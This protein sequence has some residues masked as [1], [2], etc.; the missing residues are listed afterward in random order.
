MKREGREKGWKSV[1]IKN[2]KCYKQ[3]YEN[4]EKKK[5]KIMMW[6]LIWLNKSIVIINATLQLLD[7]YRYRLKIKSIK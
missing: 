3:L 1:S 4:W 7:I 6:T 2:N 5:R